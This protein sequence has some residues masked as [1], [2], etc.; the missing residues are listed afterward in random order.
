MP[1]LKRHEGYL[2]IDHSSCLGGGVAEAATYTCNHCKAVVVLNPLRTRQRT[3]CSGC[4]HYICDT[5]AA[6]RIN[7]GVCT[8]WEKIAEMVQET[9]VKGFKT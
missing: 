5:C 1:S 6:V 4:D 9:A 2:L 7:T 8:P 3:Y